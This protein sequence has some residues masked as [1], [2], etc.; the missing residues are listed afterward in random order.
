MTF[1]AGQIVTAAALNGILPDFAAYTPTHS[2]ITVGN[3]TQTARYV[4]LGDLV[5]VNF[6]FAL[7]ST[8]A[9]G[10]GPRVGMP[11]A[12]SGADAVAS[13]RYTDG[14]THYDGQA[15]LASGSNSILLLTAAGAQVSATAPF[16]WG[17]NDAIRLS[18]TYE[19]A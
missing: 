12:A 9:I 19:G 7:G 18:I 1:L 6:N 8:S 3:A 2:N 17:L 5:V 10:T 16:T 4:R 13:V 14:T 15:I 11:V